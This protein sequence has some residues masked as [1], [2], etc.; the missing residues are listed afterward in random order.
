MALAMAVGACAPVHV[1][2]QE[3]PPYWRRPGPA[4]QEPQERLRVPDDGFRDFLAMAR[5]APGTAGG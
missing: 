3:R 1:G 2:D 4:L 5:P